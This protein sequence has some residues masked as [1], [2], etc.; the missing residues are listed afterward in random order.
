MV[1]AFGAAV[2]VVQNPELLA[3][4]IQ[5]PIG[6]KTPT[7]VLADLTWEQMFVGVVLLSL[8]QIP[9]T[10]GTAVIVIKE[11]NNRS[12]IDWCR[13]AESQSRPAS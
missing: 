4:L 8:P 9:L 1:L 2:G 7:F 10:L 11:E 12:R 13:R 5:T 3:Q 6:I